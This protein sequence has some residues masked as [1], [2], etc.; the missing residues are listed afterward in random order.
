[1][2]GRRTARLGI[3]AVAIA[4]DIGERYLDTL[5][6]G[7]WVED[8]YGADVLGSIETVESGAA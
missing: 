7:Y 1:M 5:Y 2:A 3:T 4:P 6:R 8:Q